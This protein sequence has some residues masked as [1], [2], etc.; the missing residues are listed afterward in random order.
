MVGTRT[1]G[2]LST[3]I[4]R[5]DSWIGRGFS[6]YCLLLIRLLI[7]GFVLIGDTVVDT[8]GGTMGL[9][10]GTSVSYRYGCRYDGLSD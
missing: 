3:S 10:H 9:V 7:H 6:K 2:R 8:V 5:R 4:R 1:L